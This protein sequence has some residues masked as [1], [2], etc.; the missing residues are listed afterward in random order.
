MHN[1]FQKEATQ[2]DKN[3]GYSDLAAE[4]RQVSPNAE[5]IDYK[6]RTTSAGCWE[7][8]NVYSES[9]A[10]MIGRPTG[11]Y[12]TLTI[13]RMDT[14]SEDEIADAADEVARKLCEICTKKKIYPERILAVGLGNRKLT[15]DS[16]GTKTAEEIKPTKHIKDFDENMFSALDCSEI[17]VLSPGVSATSG[18]ESAEIIKAVSDKILPDVIITI[19]SIVSRSVERLG[20]T[21]QISD[22]GIY[23][24]SGV[25]N[26]KKGINQSSMG[27]PV[28]AIGVPTVIDS[29]IFSS[30]D[31]KEERML[32][33]PQEIDEITSTAA[34]IIGMAINQ[35][36]GR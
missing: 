22:T 30:D 12:D 14:L 29:R 7:E 2:S 17:S 9:A 25:G 36:F 32:V 35:A 24:G 33:T 18:M 10:K 16:V 23:P 20:T 8:I 11:S 13:N 15:P 27:A 19:D 34:K 21:V 6:K 4:R 28:I 31:K 26:T 3:F 1:N 5:G